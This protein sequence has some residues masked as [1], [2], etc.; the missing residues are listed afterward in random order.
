MA[1][2]GRQAIKTLG[3]KLQILALGLQIS[4][5]IVLKIKQDGKNNL[6]P[7]CLSAQKFYY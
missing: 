4:Y 5:P 6:F 3:Q 7:P 2:A 1:A